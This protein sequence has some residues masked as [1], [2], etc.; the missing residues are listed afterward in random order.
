M[1]EGIFNKRLPLEIIYTCPTI[2][3]LAKQL[4]SGSK[5]SPVKSLMKVQ[6]LGNKRPFFC[7]HGDD[8][9][10]YLARHL[11]QDRPFYAFFHQGRD[12]NAFRYKTVDAI[13]TAYIEELQRAQPHGPYFIGGYSFGGTIAYEIAQKLLQS[14]EQVKLLVLFDSHCP[15]ASNKIL[16]GQYFFNQSSGT[17]EAAK[18][19]P[20]QPPPLSFFSRLVQKIQ[21]ESERLLSYGFLAL[22]NTVPVAL[23]KNYIMGIYRAAKQK[24]CV[25]HYPGDVCLFRSTQNNCDDYYLG[26]EKHIKGT[27]IVQEIQANHYTL[28][29]EPHVREVGRTLTK[30]LDSME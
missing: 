19:Q 13:A 29:Q 4:E 18:N 12:G 25:A 5:H 22:G 20:V 30:I 28:I 6:P 10:F 27:F 24:Y 11:G 17:L 15:G 7:V 23:R 26:W 2:K 1:A 14:G 3:D 9:N 21:K 16:H 8:G